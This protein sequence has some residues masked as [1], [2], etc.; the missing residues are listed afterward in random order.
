MLHHEL[1]NE[2]K[3]LERVLPHAH[4]GPFPSSYWHKRVAALTGAARQ[5]QY[6]ARIEWLKKTIRE[7]EKVTRPV[8]AQVISTSDTY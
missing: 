8:A 5:P 2:L 3:H 7:I 4:R 6:S 1:E